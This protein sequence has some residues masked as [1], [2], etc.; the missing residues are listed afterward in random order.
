MSRDYRPPWAGGRARECWGRVSRM[1]QVPAD[2]PP[3]HGPSSPHP[4]RVLATLGGCAGSCAGALAEKPFP[5]TLAGRGGVGQAQPPPCSPAVLSTSLSATKGCVWREG[6]GLCFP[7]VRARPSD[8]LP[9]AQ[10]RAR[11]QRMTWARTPHAGGQAEPLGF[12]EAFLEEV[13]FQLD[14]EEEG[15]GHA[16]P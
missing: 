1:P 9:P 8:P 5:F 12:R 4:C 16:L 6:S 13:T 2:N 10:D 7:P 14:L 15:R 3:P 11:R